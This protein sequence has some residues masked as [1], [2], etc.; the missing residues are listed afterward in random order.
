MVVPAGEKTGPS[1]GQQGGTQILTPGSAYAT[2]VGEL[3][4]APVLQSIPGARSVPPKFEG[5]DGFSG[6]TWTE[7]PLEEG[8]KTN[9]Y[10][11]WQ[12]SV[13]DANW[14][15]II[16]P[17]TATVE[18]VQAAAKVKLRVAYN[19]E[20]NPSSRTPAVDPIEIGP[21]TKFRV[22]K[23]G[24]AKAVTIVINVPGPIDSGLLKTLQ[25]AADEVVVESDY[26]AALPNLTVK[27]VSLQ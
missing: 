18:S 4:E 17:E 19:A 2:S 21:N 6:G 15:S 10:T 3:K 16:S 24:P 1:L 20:N 26:A 12:Q 25:G 11:V 14:I 5:Y 9:P 13:K 7:A 22:I 23:E 8:T 27:V